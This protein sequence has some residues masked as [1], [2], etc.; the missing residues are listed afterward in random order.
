M[1]DPLFSRCIGY[2]L[3]GAA[4]AI[5]TSGCSTP[6]KMSADQLA[7]IGVVEG[8]R[9]WDAQGRLARE[10]Y[11]CFVTGEKR[12]NF[13]CSKTVG[14]FPTCLSRVE[15]VADDNNLVSRL[16]V[17]DPACMGTP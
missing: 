5:C 10:G 6:A 13:S 11:Q 8:I 4:V 16:R 12:E 7:A 1:Q 9:Y 2:L 3:V 14:L 17:A 15:F